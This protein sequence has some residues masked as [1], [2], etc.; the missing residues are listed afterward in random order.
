M[1]P[2]LYLN[3]HT[4]DQTDDQ[5]YEAFIGLGTKEFSQERFFTWVN[6]HAKPER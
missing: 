4:L 6:R 2:F 1:F 5:I 3:G